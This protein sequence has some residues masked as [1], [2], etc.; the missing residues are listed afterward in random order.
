MNKVFKVIWNKARNCYMV[1]SELAKR[2]T[3]SPSLK[4]SIFSKTLIAGIFTC[5]ISSSISVA[6]VFAASKIKYVAPSGTATSDGFISF[7]LRDSFNLYVNGKEVSSAQGSDS[8]VGYFLNAGD[9]WIVKGPYPEYTEPVSEDQLWYGHGF[10]NPIDSASDAIKELSIN[11]RTITY[12]KADGTK[13][14]I[15]TQDTNTTYSAGNGLSLSGTTFSAKAGTNVTVNGSGINV[16]GNGSV[17]SGNTGLIDGGKLYSEVRP[18][19]NGNYVKHKNS[20]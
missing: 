8:W 15:T 2:K 4:R 3:K 5:L 17:V 9:T 1:V 18:S 16:T 19:G 14:T 11:G 13:G 12:I 6:P 20:I 7:V 10:F